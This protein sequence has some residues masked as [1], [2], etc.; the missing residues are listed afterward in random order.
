MD[1][2]KVWVQSVVLPCPV[3]VRKVTLL[4]LGCSHYFGIPREDSCS[5]SS[6]VY[7]NLVKTERTTKNNNYNYKIYPTR[8]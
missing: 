5:T 8:G 3:H 7:F 4:V 6:T 1:D 2:T